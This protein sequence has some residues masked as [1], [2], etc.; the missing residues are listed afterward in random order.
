MRPAI[1]AALLLALTA[2]E[3]AA[4][5]GGVAD[6]DAL[7]KAQQACAANGGELKL[8]PNGDAQDIQ[9]YACVRK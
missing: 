5:Q 7:R 8:K 2:C 4:N 3:T 9:D 6:Y 1:A